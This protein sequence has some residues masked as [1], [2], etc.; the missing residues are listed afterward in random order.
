MTDFSRICTVENE[1]L[2]FEGESDLYKLCE[3]YITELEDFITIGT[4]DGF[5]S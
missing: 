5:I 2:E 3:R 1:T 4:I